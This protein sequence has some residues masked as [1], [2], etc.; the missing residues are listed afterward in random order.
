[1]TY[2]ILFHRSHNISV[3]VSDCLG[4]IESHVSVS[5]RQRG[6]CHRAGGHGVGQHCQGELKHKPLGQKVAM[7]LAKG[8]KH[9]R[10]LRTLPSNKSS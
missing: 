3:S 1:M 2:H 7:Y 8:R 4:Q 10:F 6:G 9:V 5:P